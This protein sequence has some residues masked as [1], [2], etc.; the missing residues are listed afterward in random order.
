MAKTKI[1][2][3]SINLHNEIEKLQARLKNDL[4]SDVSLVKT[5]DILAKIIKDNDFSAR[6]N[7]G[8]SEPKKRRK[9]IIEFKL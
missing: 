8:I 6:L 7:I 9:S 3:I 2:K 1:S 5:T 4:N